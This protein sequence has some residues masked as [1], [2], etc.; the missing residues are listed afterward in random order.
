M[1]IISGTP[2]I[3]RGTTPTHTIG[4]PPEVGLIAKARV[5]YAQD[6]KAV[7]KKENESCTIE[8]DSVSVKL[9]QEDT[10]SLTCSKT[11]EIELHVLT[12]GNDSIISEP[13]VAVVT[14]CLDNEVLV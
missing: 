13:I 5:V 2:I 6:G 11:C 14:K 8:E 7:F 3:K 12:P 9:T 1:D 10:L 4:V